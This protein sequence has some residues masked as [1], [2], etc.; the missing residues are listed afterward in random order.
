MSRGAGGDDFGILFG[1]AFVQ[2]GGQALAIKLGQFGDVALDGVLFRYVGG[3]IF[4]DLVVVAI[5]VG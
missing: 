3:K 5:D 1:R 2:I 4:I